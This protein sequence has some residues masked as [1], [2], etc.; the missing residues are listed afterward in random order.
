MLQEVVSRWEREALLSQ[1]ESPVATCDMRW[2]SIHFV[3]KCPEIQQTTIST[4]SSMTGL[5]SIT[6]LF[7]SREIREE[8]R[9][10]KKQ[11]LFVMFIK[12]VNF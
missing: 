6:A 4:F 5:S 10:F 3:L 9:S 1:P 11:I 2:T 12:S 7:H 8:P